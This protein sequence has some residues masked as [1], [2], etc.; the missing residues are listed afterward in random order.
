M[1]RRSQLNSPP[2]FNSFLARIRRR[3]SANDISV[4]ESNGTL[5]ETIVE[6]TELLAEQF[7][8]LLSR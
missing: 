4:L 1:K 3:A 5:A 7:F 6:K 8:D 2:C